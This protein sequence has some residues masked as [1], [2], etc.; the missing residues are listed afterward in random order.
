[1]KNINIAIVISNKRREMGI[2]QEELAS[3]AGVTKASVSK[4]ETGLSYPD[5]EIIPVLA[6]FF[7]ITVDELI[8]YSPQMSREQIAETYTRLTDGF[9]KRPFKDVYEECVDLVKA[10]YSCYPLLLN[11][12][13]LL[14]NHYM[15][16][17]NPESQQIAL[18]E[19][20]KLCGRVREESRDAALVVDA[21]AMEA[22]ALLV[23]GKADEALEL[24]NPGKSM[25]VDTTQLIAQAHMMLGEADSAK[26]AL[27]NALYGHIIESV[28]Y[29][30]TLLHVAGTPPKWRREGIRRIASLIELF[31]LDDLSP[32]ALVNPYASVAMA[33][34]GLGDSDSA[35]A[36]LSKAVDLLCG[37]ALDSL[38]TPRSDGF[39]DHLTLTDANTSLPK[40]Q[41]R[42]VSVIRASMLNDVLK[43]PVFKGLSG[44]PKYGAMI[45]LL[46]EKGVK[47]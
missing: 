10:Y 30:A 1:M 24:L 38:G 27:Q 11:L 26:A 20:I 44:S 33:S 5:L 13:V 6:S 39:F 17:L 15:L 36:E 35:L 2:T 29:L 43:N 21:S 42:D 23:S 19:S 14:I 37:G 41:P 28:G 32:A 8:G 9:A 46:E 47:Q 4:W 16:A 18:R 40:T 3:H 45:R 7:G 34:M 22:T 25:R 12:A 31:H